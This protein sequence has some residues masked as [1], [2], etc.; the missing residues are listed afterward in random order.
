MCIISSVKT[1]ASIM[2][3]SIVSY[4]VNPQ[5]MTGHFVH[6]NIIAEDNWKNAT[7][8]A[9]HIISRLIILFRLAQPHN[10]QWEMFRS[11]QADNL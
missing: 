3:F 5:C 11:E 1:K 6:L 4:I 9:D 10:Q 8:I 2:T 7:I